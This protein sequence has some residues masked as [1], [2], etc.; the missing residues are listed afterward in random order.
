M[1]INCCLSLYVL[2]LLAA[3][4]LGQSGGDKSQNR[5][6]R[7]RE[8]LGLGKAPDPVAAERGSVI[9][10]RNCA[11]CHGTKANGAEGPALV[12]SSL[13]LHD[14]GGDQIG[15]MLLKGRP[16]RGMPA[17]ASFTTEQIKDVSAFLHQRVELAANRGTYKLQNIVTG[18]ASEG[19]KYFAGKGGCT[20]CHS[21]TGNLAHVGS[22]YQPA[23]LQAAFLYPA[24]VARSEGER[25]ATVTLA[26]GEKITGKLALLDDFDVALV[27]TDGN[28][29]S[30]PRSKGI[31]VEV[32]DLLLRHR[33]LLAQYSDADMH[34]LL[35]YLV[36]LK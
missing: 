1:K 21:A 19:E 34:N 35:S 27:D 30:W 15:P 24:T 22:K 16:D 31:T 32:E 36:T 2:L 20:Q 28:Y 7:T 12:R 18:D 13:V 29:R 14:G 33:E 25:Q 4:A 8:F 11:F 9:Y 3:N 26:S 17:F 6:D 23:E 5:A 10:S